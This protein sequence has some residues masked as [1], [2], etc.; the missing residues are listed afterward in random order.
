MAWLQVVN[1]YDRDVFNGDQGFV[2]EVGPHRSASRPPTMASSIPHPALR[3]V[4]RNL[5]PLRSCSPIIPEEATKVQSP[6]ARQPSSQSE[7]SSWVPHVACN[8]GVLQLL[9]TTHT[10]AWPTPPGRTGG[11]VGPKGSFIT[12]VFNSST[13]G[14]GSSSDTSGAGSLNPSFAPA[15]GGAAGQAGAAPKQPVKYAGR[16][17]DMLELAWATTVR[18]GPFSYGP[19]FVRRESHRVSL[20]CTQDAAVSH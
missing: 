4:G 12:V 14:Q 1:D 8:R 17:A 3:I 9:S 18:H 20:P 5:A 10:A 15:A 6:C 16:Q 2:H 13:A 7:S 19:S 11:Q